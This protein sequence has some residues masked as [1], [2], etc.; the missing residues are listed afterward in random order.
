MASCWA[1]P[2]RVR[3]RFLRLSSCLL[4]SAW[5][6]S[7][8]NHCD[9]A[10]V[11]SPIF[12]HLESKVQFVHNFPFSKHEYTSPCLQVSYCLQPLF[13]THTYTH[14]HSLSLSLSFSHTHTYTHT[15]SLSLTHIHTLSLSLSCL[16]TRFLSLIR[17]QYRACMHKYVNNNLF[18]YVFV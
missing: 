9:L 14:T 2:S 4:L 8:F 11:E 1:G 5:R 12:L 13:H 6:Q 17:L 7:H 16:L 3:S 15:L 10:G 18:V